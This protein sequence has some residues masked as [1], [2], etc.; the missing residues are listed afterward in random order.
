MPSFSHPKRT[1]LYPARKS[2]PTMTITITITITIIN[3]Q[4]DLTR[5]DMAWSFDFSRVV[6]VDLV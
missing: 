6:W 3:H 1:L 5:L 4:R 2:S